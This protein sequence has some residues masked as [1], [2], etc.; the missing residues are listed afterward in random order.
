LSCALQR[1]LHILKLVNGQQ[2]RFTPNNK[3]HPN[4]L[5]KGEMPVFDE[6]KCTH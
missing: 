3:K 5:A 2:T 6:L 4:H 1:A